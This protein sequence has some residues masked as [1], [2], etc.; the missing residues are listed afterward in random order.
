MVRVALET[1]RAASKRMV[2]RC[3]LA[4]Y[5]KLDVVYEVLAFPDSTSTLAVLKFSS[6][7]LMTISLVSATRLPVML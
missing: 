2:A 6:R 5:W 1:G 7:A 4:S 3:A